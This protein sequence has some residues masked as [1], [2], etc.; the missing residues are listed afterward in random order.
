MKALR[1]IYYI[2]FAFSA[3]ISV[4]IIYNI[5]CGENLVPDTLI[6]AVILAAAQI[7]GLVF[8]I[9][10]RSRIM[11]GILAV[12]AGI[13]AFLLGLRL[14]LNDRMLGLTF[15]ILGDILYVCFVTVGVMFFILWLE[16]RNTKIFEATPQNIEQNIERK[17]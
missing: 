7:A 17:K 16:N 15:C 13:A 6:I 12:L 4:N 8:V 11:S 14:V 2:L 9:L 5:A 10:D 3:L 1:T